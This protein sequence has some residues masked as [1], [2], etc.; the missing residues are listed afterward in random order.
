M[1]KVI[2]FILV[3]VVAVGFICGTIYAAF[4]YGFS[5]GV[6]CI[7]GYSDADK[8]ETDTGNSTGTEKD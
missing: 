8:D 6:D 5:G 7:T 3:P 2:S 1:N 4:F